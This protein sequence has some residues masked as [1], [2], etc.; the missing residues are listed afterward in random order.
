MTIP[1][2]GLVRREVFRYHRSMKSNTT[3]LKKTSVNVDEDVWRRFRAQCILEG[4]EIGATLAGLIEAW[5]AKRKGGS[6]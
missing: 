3:R 1:R 5:L 4:R 6:R 2:S